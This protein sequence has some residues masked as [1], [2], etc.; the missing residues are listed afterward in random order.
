MSLRAGGPG[1]RCT[2]RLRFG[3]VEA[4]MPDVRQRAPVPPTAYIH[5]VTGPAG[6][7]QKFP[8]LGWLSQD[9]SHSREC[10]TTD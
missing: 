4:R 8:V 2:E 5:V 7:L 9:R 3:S 6:H 10:A 1:N